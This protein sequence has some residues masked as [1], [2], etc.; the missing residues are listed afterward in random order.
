VIA[1][2]ESPPEQV[3]VLASSEAGGLAIRG[4]ILRVGGYVAGIGLALASV[5]FLTRHLGVEDF[6]R[7][8]TVVALIAVVGLISD[9][10]LTVVGVREYAL[11][12]ESGRERLVRNLVGL[13][14]VIAVL[15]VAAATVFALLAG[16]EDSMVAGTVLAGIGLVLVVVQQAYVIPLQAGLRLGLVTALDLARQALTVVGILGLVAAGAGLVAFLG[17]PVPVGAAVMIATVLAIRGRRVVRPA[18][19][20]AEWAY[21]TREALPV[22]VASTIGAFFYRIAIIVMSLLATAE[23]TGYFSASFRI[24]EAI[25]VV[26]GLVTAA[27]FP[28]VA[29]AAYEHRERLRIS[30]QKLFDIAVVFGSWTA[31]CVVLGAGPAMDLVGGPGFEP[32]EQV[33]RVQGIALGASF[34]LSVWASG[35]WALREQ[36]ALAWTNA[37]GVV[38]AAAL[39]AALIPA[40]GA[41]GAAIA[42]TIAESL[43]AAL[44]A[45][46]LMR[47]RPE[48]RPPLGVVPKTLLAAGLALALWAAPVHD[49]VKVVLATVVFFAVVLVLRAVPVEVSRALRGG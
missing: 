21:L 34:L 43:L 17:I 44:Y 35:L 26:P 3:D 49:I 10:G 28:I 36:R 37:V 29:R 45:F 12:D 31:V 19:D 15:G 8:I 27:A 20:R 32:A 30:L 11:R 4:G 23:E 9:A 14:A 18:F 39:T 42:M 41:L 7:Y 5:P 38:V 47:G 40:H 6:G 33:L 22:A 48:L 1:S 24:V 46:A 25:I 16:Y 13:R 2:N